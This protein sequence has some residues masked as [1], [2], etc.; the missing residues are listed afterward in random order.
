MT[1]QAL[2]RSSAP[3]NYDALAMLDIHEIDCFALPAPER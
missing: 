1:T 2:G 3:A